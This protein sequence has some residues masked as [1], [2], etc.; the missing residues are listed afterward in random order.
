MEFCY[1]LMIS[2][3]IFSKIHGKIREINGKLKKFCLLLAF[4]RNFSAG[5]HKKNLQSIWQRCP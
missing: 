3:L 5:H 1:F 2:R 4:S